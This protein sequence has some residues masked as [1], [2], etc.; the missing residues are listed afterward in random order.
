MTDDRL[1]DLYRAHGPDALRLAYVLTGDREAAEDITQDAFVRI[2]RKIFGLRDTD[3]ERAYLFRTVIN[4]CRSRGRKL[5]RERAAIARL[6]PPREATEPEDDETWGRLLS[7]PSRQRA[8]LFF[9]YYLDQSETSSAEALNCST[10][11]L[12]SLVNRGLKTLRKAQ[13]DER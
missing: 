8:A 1:G 2:G 9:R 3:H 13:G 5:R 6:Q 4:L 10:S 11:A 7:L 12:K